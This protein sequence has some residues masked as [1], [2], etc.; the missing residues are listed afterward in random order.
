[1]ASDPATA[2]G[3]AD[4]IMASIDSDGADARLVIADISD[5]GAWLSIPEGAAAP[6]GEWC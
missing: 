6:L 2:Q 3:P 4:E 5:D 1:M